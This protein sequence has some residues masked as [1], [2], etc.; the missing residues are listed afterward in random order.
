MAKS[1]TNALVGILVREGNLSVTDPAPVRAWQSDER[2]RITIN[3]LL[4][5]QSGLLWSE[6]YFTVSDV[7]RMIFLA[8]DMSKEAAR[9]P[10]AHP[11]GQKWLYSSGTTNV[12]SQII[13][14]TVGEEQHLAFP[15]RA[16][17][18]HLGM[19]SAV[20]ETD[21]SGTF[22]GSS[23]LLAT[24]R[25]WA[26]FG[27]LYLND[28]IWQGQRVLPEGWVNYTTT[29]VPFAPQ[30]Q[31]GAHFWLNVGEAADPADRPF[32]DAPTDT[33]FAQGFD[34]QNVFIIPSRQLVIVRA[35]GDHPGQF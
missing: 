18:N 30:R 11:P 14:E 23:Y 32:P 26:K 28:G 22:V 10:L 29:P 20:W 12:L 8:E 19:S 5:M 1:V 9:Q 3:D 25:D 6:N 2:Q 33:Y 35:G 27:Q 21:L 34:G 13:R 16:L 15:Y 17:F 31:Y 24:A 7:S 4:R